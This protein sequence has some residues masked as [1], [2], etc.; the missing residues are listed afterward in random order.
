[1]MRLS[2]INPDNELVYYECL[3][4]APPDEN[5]ARFVGSAGAG[6]A[7]DVTWI[8][9]STGVLPQRWVTSIGVEG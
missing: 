8:Q 7:S 4:P 2:P 9:L 5:C 3:Q 6:P 1:M